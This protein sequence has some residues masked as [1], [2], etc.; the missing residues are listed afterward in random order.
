MS[1]V[2]AQKRAIEDQYDIEVLIDVFYAKI[3]RNKELSPFFSEAVKNWTYHKQQFVKYWSAQVLFTDS[4][5]GSILPHHVSVDQ[6]YGSGFTKAHFDEW[7][8]L[9]VETVDELFEGEKAE[10]AKESAQNVAKNI[11]LKMFVNRK[12]T[13]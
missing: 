13:F 7:T 11:Y 5:E 10:L 12:S 6:K 1:K 3:L 2:I 8:R 4:Y 9:F